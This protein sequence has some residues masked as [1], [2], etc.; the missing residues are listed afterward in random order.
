MNRG[1]GNPYPLFGYSESPYSGKEKDEN[2]EATLSFE[3]I[4]KYFPGVQ[5]LSNVSFSASGGRV[6]ALMG[7]NGAGKSTLLKIPIML[8]VRESASYIRSGRYCRSC[9]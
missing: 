1:R 6:L 9:P 2:M 4:S 3:H 8:S 5:A 7:E